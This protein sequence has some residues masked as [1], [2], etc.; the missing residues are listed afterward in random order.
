MTPQEHDKRVVEEFEQVFGGD[1]DGFSDKPRSFSSDLRGDSSYERF[2][3]AKV[4]SF[5]L[6]KLK[7]R[8]E[9]NVDN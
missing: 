8:D 5:L 2:L 1:Y 9:M 4:K 7:E 6:Q 3:F